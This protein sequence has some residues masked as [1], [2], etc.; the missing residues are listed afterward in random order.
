MGLMVRASDEM[1]SSVLRQYPAMCGVCMRFLWEKGWGG[2]LLERGD[3]R[4][5]QC[6]RTE[7]GLQQ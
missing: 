6:H 7:A 5:R 4:P 2:C 3:F 1:G